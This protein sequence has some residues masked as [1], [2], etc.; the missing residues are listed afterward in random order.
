MSDFAENKRICNICQKE[1]ASNKVIISLSTN[2]VLLIYLCHKCFFDYMKFIKETINNGDIEGLQKL[3]LDVINKNNFSVFDN[4]SVEHLSN[5]NNC[6]AGIYN[7]VNKNDIFD[8]LINN[9]KKNNNVI[10]KYI[11][12]IEE[13]YSNNSDEFGFFEES[14]KFLEK[15]NLKDF[16]NSL[17]TIEQIAE[18]IREISILC[19]KRFID[20]LTIFSQKTLSKK[21]PVCLTTL[22][23]ILDRS[24]IGCQFCLYYF[25]DK[26]DIFVKSLKDYVINI[27]NSKPKDIK[28]IEQ[29]IHITN[30][31]K[32]SAIDNKD[33][34]LAKKYKKELDRLTKKYQNKSNFNRKKSKKEKQ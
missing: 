12:I 10:A 28:E 15:D 32:K 1:N 9:K 20:P 7:N 19:E 30:I 31:L 2:S 21:C 24:N 4:L 8:K 17:E 5:T 11:D 14:N 22:M 23:D 26:I 25:K 16:N 6:E 18:A 29:K 13:A 27:Y 33:W 3:C 34:D